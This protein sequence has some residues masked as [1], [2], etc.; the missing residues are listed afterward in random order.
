M[1][2][3]MTDHDNELRRA[4]RGLPREEPPAALDAAILARA[5]ERV[6][7]R[8]RPS[9]M[10]PVSIAAV[11]VLGIGVSLRMQ[12]EQ[13][14]VETS[15]PAPASAPKP[16]P[17]KKVDASSAKERRDATPPQA[18]VAAQIP[19]GAAA[20]RED[21][22][23]S[24]GAV[25]APP[26]Q[27]TTSVATEPPPAAASA[28]APAAAPAAPALRIAPQ[29]MQTPMRA[30]RE[31]EGASAADAAGARDLRKSLAAPDADPAREL[32]RIAQLRAEGRH[33]EAD[34]ALEAFR[35]Q[36]PDYRIPDAVWERVKPR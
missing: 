9:W 5:R 24:A 25:S 8:P 3:T 20:T 16:A 7:P 31:A 33:A 22:P 29:A 32:E 21:K 17:Q 23:V 12:M 4:Y 26:A 27:T 2:W 18:N 13:P 1:P 34:R 19:L 11:L 10:V 30:K 35:R 6:V 15:V 14:G 36:R 28:P